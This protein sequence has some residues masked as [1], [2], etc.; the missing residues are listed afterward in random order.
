MSF[1]SF[2]NSKPYYIMFD[3]EERDAKRYHNQVVP[4]ALVNDEF[5]TNAKFNHLK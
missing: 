3:T 1:G 2:R 4:S 5:V